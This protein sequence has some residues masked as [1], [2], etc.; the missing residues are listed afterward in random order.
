MRIGVYWRSFRGL[1]GAPRVAA[2]MI[3]S[4]GKLGHE[5]VVLTNEYD[6]KLYP[7]LEGRRILCTKKGILR[8]HPAGKVFD[9]VNAAFFL[10]KQIR[11]LD[12]L[13]LT[14]M[15]F[16]SAPMKMVADTKIILYVHAPV[17]ID[18]TLNP[19]IRKIL[20]KLESRLYRSADFVLSNSRL[21]QNTLREHLRL[22]SEVLYPPVDTKFFAYNDAKEAAVVSI[23]RLHPK[24][25]S[26]LMIELF[27]NLKGDYRFFL[28]GAIEE[29]FTEY[30]KRLTEAA[31]KDRRISVL[32]NPS[33]QE[34]KDLYAKASVFWYIYTKEE[35]GLPVAEAMSCGTPVVALQGGGV[36]EIVANNRTGFLVSTREEL[37]RKT[38]FLLSDPETRREMGLAARK[39]TE[40]NFSC[41]VFLKR[42]QLVVS[43]VF[44]RSSLHSDSAEA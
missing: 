2:N 20:K 25:R 7:T 24:K 15:Y 37:L 44:G 8:G 17:C 32:F 16:A 33:D 10:T 40:E 18:W 35:F 9:A 19:T 34:I 42:V 38:D 1:G 41:N 14:G 23:C 29:K 36:N 43:R 22:D 30:G 13:F 28:A 11:D 12:G 6:V 21:T 26:E 31:S 27:Q 39:R 5:P 4:L 3:D